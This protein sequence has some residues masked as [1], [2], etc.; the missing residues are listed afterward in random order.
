MFKVYH[1]CDTL[2]PC[3]SINAQNRSSRFFGLLLRSLWGFP[4][5]SSMPPFF[6]GL[7]LGIPYNKSNPRN[8]RLH[9]N[10]HPPSL[11]S[12]ILLSL[13]RFLKSATLCVSLRETPRAECARSHALS[14]SSCP[15]FAS[16]EAS[17]FVSRRRRIGIRLHLCGMRR[18]FVMQ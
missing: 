3:F 17:S 1:S 5:S 18:A 10:P 13:R 4:W 6:K 14:F 16:Q 7:P 8:R 9:L 12:L 15:F 2:T 11:M